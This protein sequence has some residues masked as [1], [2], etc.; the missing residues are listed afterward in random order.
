MIYYDKETS[1]NESL[2]LMFKPYAGI[3][4]KEIHKLI[5]NQ[6]LLNET[7]IEAAAKEQDTDLGKLAVEFKKHCGG[8]DWASTLAVDH[9]IMSRRT[10]S[11]CRRPA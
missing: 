1:K 2:N 6:L 9:Q 8:N 11:T 3:Y 5:I 10:G 7:E 4:E